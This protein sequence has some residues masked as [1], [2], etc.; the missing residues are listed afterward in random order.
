M[1]YVGYENMLHAI[2]TNGSITWTGTTS[3]RIVSSP[4]IDETNNTVYIGSDDDCLYAF[5]IANGSVKWQQQTNS[6]VASSPA[7]AKGVVYIGSD[8]GNVYAFDA[9]NGD[10]KWSFNTGD[11]VHSSPAVVNGV[12]YIGSNNG[13]IYALDASNGDKKWF[14]QTSAFITS[15]PVIS[16]GVLY[17]ASWDGNV[18]AFHNG[19]AAKWEPVIYTFPNPAKDVSSL[20]FRYLLGEGCEVNIDIYDMNYD[21]IASLDGGEFQNDG[22]Y[23]K[24]WDISNIGSGVYMYVFKA[25]NKKVVKKLTIVK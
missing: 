4:T 10:K 7:I 20:T 23:E 12:V 5:D 8:D 24:L 6:D 14:Y 1:I 11:E 9:Q 21:L 19:P 18:Y 15:S 17:V 16:N 2:T 25:G 13:K 22:Y 3:E